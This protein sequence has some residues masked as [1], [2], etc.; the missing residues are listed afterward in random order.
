MLLLMMLLLMMLLLLMMSMMRMLILHEQL[1]ETDAFTQR[2]LLKG[3][4]TLILLHTGACTHE[5]F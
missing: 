3:F 4:Y 1:L 5:N 2:L